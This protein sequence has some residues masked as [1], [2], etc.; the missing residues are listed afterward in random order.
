MPQRDQFLAK[1]RTVKSWV[2]RNTHTTVQVNNSL[3][4]PPALDWVCT[5]PVLG[6]IG[7][8]VSSAVNLVSLMVTKGKNTY[9]VYNSLTMKWNPRCTQGEFRVH[10]VQPPSCPS[11]DRW[12][13]SFHQNEHWQEWAHVPL[14]VYISEQLVAGKFFI[15]CWTCN[16]C[17]L[18]AVY[19]SYKQMG[20]MGSQILE[21]WGTIPALPPISWATSGSFSQASN[22]WPCYFNW[23]VRIAASTSRR[24]CGVTRDDASWS[25]DTAR[26]TGSSLKQPWN[27][28]PDSRNGPG[29]KALSGPTSGRP[30]CSSP[31][32]QPCP[33]SLSTPK[34]GIHP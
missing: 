32:L 15:L 11:P 27:A 18:L 25:P 12:P 21:F 13:A 23:K 24:L 22:V 2:Q 33:S 30:P 6:T 7:T 34:L 28:R 31:S 9:N 10:L 5:L 8:S 16:L 19:R 3:L 17:L 1:T 29:C 26:G 14:P 4:S 20:R